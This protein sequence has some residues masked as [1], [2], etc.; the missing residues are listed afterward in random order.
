M[1]FRSLLVKADFWAYEQEWRVIDH[2]DGAGAHRYEPASLDA[3][4][5]GVRISAEARAAVLKW[6]EA[7]KPPVQVMHATFDPVHFRLVIA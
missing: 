4:I 5:L 2:I 7:H 1:L 6:A 3:I